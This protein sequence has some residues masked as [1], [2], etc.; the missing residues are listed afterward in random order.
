MN[1]NHL[2]DNKTNTKLHCHKHSITT[3]INPQSQPDQMHL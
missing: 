2:T 3:K 1:K